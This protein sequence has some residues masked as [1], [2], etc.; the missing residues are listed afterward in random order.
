M[1]REGAIF[2][3]T[4]AG[5]LLLSACETA[6]LNAPLIQSYNK[7]KVDAMKEGVTKEFMKNNLNVTLQYAEQMYGN[8]NTLGEPE[9]VSLSNGERPLIYLFSNITTKEGVEK[10]MLIGYVDQNVDEKKLNVINKE[11]MYGT[12]PNFEIAGYFDDQGEFVTIIKEDDNGTGVLDMATGEIVMLGK[13]KDFL[14]AFMEY[15]T[16]PAAAQSLPTATETPYQTSSDFVEVTVTPIPQEVPTEIISATETIDAYAPELVAFVPNSVEQIGMSVEVRSDK[17]GYKEDVNKVLDVIH[18]DILPGYTGEYVEAKV[19][20]LVVRYSNNLISFG[21]GINLNPI[22]SVHSEWID[23]KGI[24]HDVL[25]LFFPAKCGEDKFLLS[26]IID[27]VRVNPPGA[28]NADNPAPDWSMAGLIGKFPMEIKGNGMFEA[29]YSLI[30]VGDDEFATAYF[31]NNDV[32]AED[33]ISELGHAYWD[34]LGGIPFT[35]EGE[36]MS[37]VSKGGQ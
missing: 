28:V 1:N 13:Q 2:S 18:N 35:R 22:A 32:K 20:Q 5:M 11:F 8:N 33:G 9:I 12:A 36:L 30:D 25:R 10:K 29:Y 26:I 3:S 19:K 37:L 4:I 7:E 31:Q 24:S 27:P 14:T 21:S 23:S 17:E 6:P 16:T 34:W 15:K